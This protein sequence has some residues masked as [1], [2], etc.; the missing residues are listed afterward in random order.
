[1]DEE[2]VRPKRI[3]GLKKNVGKDELHFKFATTKLQKHILIEKKN[4][5]EEGEGEEVEEKT[6][7]RETQCFIHSG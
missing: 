2:I 6:V 4:S 7:A 3:I 5:A 1:M